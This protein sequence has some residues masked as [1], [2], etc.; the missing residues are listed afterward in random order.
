LKNYG[1]GIY[2]FDL[3]VPGKLKPGGA[4]GAHPAKT[5]GGS[6][7]MAPPTK[8]CNHPEDRG[9]VARLVGQ[10]TSWCLESEFVDALELDRYEERAR[11]INEVRAT[12]RNDD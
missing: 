6:H 4:G 3:A 7:Y 1:S 2:Y 5:L 10:G 8:D 11:E 9:E 12:E